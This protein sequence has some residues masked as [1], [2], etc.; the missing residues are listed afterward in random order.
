MKEVGLWSSVL[1]GDG[2]HSRLVTEMS[3]RCVT[4]S[5]TAA[6]G[7]RDS[8]YRVLSALLHRRIGAAGRCCESRVKVTMQKR[9]VSCRGRVTLAPVA[10]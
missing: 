2:L 8:P 5:A 1:R 6:P 4:V 10:A 9:V 3:V 7:S